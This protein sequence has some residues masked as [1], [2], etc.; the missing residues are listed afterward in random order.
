[1][2]RPRRRALSP[3]RLSSFAAA[4]LLMTGSAEA[5]VDCAHVTSADRIAFD[6][7][8]SAWHRESESIQ[9]SSNAHDYVSLPSFRKI[10]G[11]G[12]G[13]VPLLHEKLVQ[14]RDIDFML[15][16]AVVT[17][18]GWNPGDFAAGSE[19]AFRDKVLR[20]LGATP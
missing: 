12:P 20:R 17:I 5:A 16:R 10:V 15:A 3:A 6:H 2:T 13:A 7:L 8:Y 19:Q 9:F 14:D 4:F 1:M 11:L 18:C